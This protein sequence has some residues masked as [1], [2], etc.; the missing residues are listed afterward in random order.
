[1]IHQDGAVRQETAT[2]SD[3]IEI[4]GI[5]F[6]GSKPDRLLVV[7]FA[8]T[9]K[10]IGSPGVH[11]VMYGDRVLESAE[12]GTGVDDSQFGGA[13]IY[14]LV[15]PEPGHKVMIRF[16]DLFPDA[17][18][19]IAVV[20]NGVD[21]RNPIGASEGTY[22]TAL[23][24]SASPHSPYSR[25]FSA[26]ASGVGDENQAARSSVETEVIATVEVENVSLNVAISNSGAEDIGV[27]FIDDRARNA[28]AV[29]ELMPV[30]DDAGEVRITQIG[31]GG[32]YFE[33]AEGTSK[34]DGTR[35]EG[36]FGVL[37]IGANGSYDYLMHPEHAVELAARTDLSESFDY[38]LSDGTE[39]VLSVPVGGAAVAEE[40]VAPVDE[41]AS[42]ATANLQVVQIN[43]RGI[44]QK[45]V[46]AGTS[47]ADG[48]MI[49]GDYGTLSIGSDGSY[50][51]LTDP[52][53][54]A[55][56]APDVEVN[57][58]FTYILSDGTRKKLSL[59]VTGSEE[60]NDQ[61][62]DQPSEE[63]GVF[64]VTEIS[65]GDGTPVPVASGSTS[66]SN[67]THVVGL[68]GTLAIGADGSYE[69]NV[70]DSLAGS[71]LVAPVEW[72]KYTSSDGAQNYPMDLRISVTIP[73]KPEEE[74]PE[75]IEI[76]SGEPDIV[77]EVPPL[78]PKEPNW[79]TSVY[80]IYV[81]EYVEN[82]DASDFMISSVPGAKILEIIGVPAESGYDLTIEAINL[83]SYGDEFRVDYVGIVPPRI[84]EPKIPEFAGASEVAEEI[85]QEQTVEEPP[86]EVPPTE[87]SGKHD[88]F[89]AEMMVSSGAVT[90][91][92]DFSNVQYTP[93]VEAPHTADAHVESTG[94]PPQKGPV[95]QM[96]TIVN[97][98]VSAPETVDPDV[99]VT[100]AVPR[101]GRTGELSEKTDSLPLGGITKLF[102]NPGD[103]RFFGGFKVETSP[104]VEGDFDLIPFFAGAASPGATVKVVIKEESGIEF[105]SVTEVADMSGNWT[106]SPKADF[107]EGANY[108][109]TLEETPA[110]WDNAAFPARIL[111]AK[112]P[113]PS[114]IASEMQQNLRD[115]Q[116]I[117]QVMVGRSPAEVIGAGETLPGGEAEMPV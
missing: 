8:G 16:S 34:E 38:I 115:G 61:P 67:P 78:E 117:G 32:R 85:P 111:E 109:I 70:D 96:S 94:T 62:E 64:E 4:S 18:A 11:S 88:F 81:D 83:K 57:E 79:E 1:M 97:G 82:V 53:S 114:K 52:D 103:K 21:Q 73:E 87:T 69:Y 92:S 29:I 65:V 80:R 102:R 24:I 20:Y 7:A 35:I 45:S 19:A 56:L 54:A 71:D 14:T 50:K 44:G 37:T 9:G 39:A 31:I 112:F 49:D 40:E 116:I 58:E 105:H 26:I 72:F 76:E 110:T 27:N 107:E 42:E 15:N 48:T 2:N 99:P 60:E 84:E 22:T 30:M 28:I 90:S 100:G 66:S 89:S 41:V 106:S 95:S 91:F 47:S 13:W 93:E 46:A 59:T 6:D 104:D 86:E 74:P 17:I 5:E 75:E 113:S 33:V 43:F 25:Y 12:S 77:E 63:P 55:R 68:Y 101:L 10:K 36:Q 98:T 3:S 108:T 51:Y 23:K